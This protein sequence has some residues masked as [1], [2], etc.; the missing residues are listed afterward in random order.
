LR[1]QEQEFDIS[2]QEAHYNTE[3]WLGKQVK[4]S[5]WLRRFEG[6]SGVHYVLEDE[7]FNRVAI[8]NIPNQRLEEIVGQLAAVEGN[9]QFDESSGIFIIAKSLILLTKK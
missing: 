8:R 6:I 9:F 2:L 3:K 7:L 1:Q 4:I 5:G